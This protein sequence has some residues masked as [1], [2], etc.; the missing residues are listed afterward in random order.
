MLPFILAYTGCNTTSMIYG[1]SKEAV[2]KLFRTSPKFRQIIEIFY[3]EEPDVNEIT[4]RSE[5]EMI[6]L[7]NGDPLEWLDILRFRKFTQKVCTSKRSV[8]VD[9]LPPTTA[10]FR[11]HS[12]R[13]YLQTQIW[14]GNNT[15][16]AVDWGWE[17]SDNKLMQ[18]GT[19]LPALEP[20]LKVIRCNCQQNCDSTRCTCRKHGLDC[21]QGCGNCRGMING[22]HDICV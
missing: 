8:Q 17:I 19:H 15:L 6:L 14:R 4:T 11:F 3:V 1:I 20:L 5:E 9:T 12:L 2:L 13:T 10:A 16:D 18:G 21:S 22:D 7:N